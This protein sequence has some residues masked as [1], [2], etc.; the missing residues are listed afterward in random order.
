MNLS[1]YNSKIQSSLYFISEMKDKDPESALVKCDKLQKE[2]EEAH[3]DALIGFSHFTKAEIHY[4][5]NE[6]VDFYVEMAACLEPFERIEEWGYL[7]MANNMLGIMSLNRG[8]APFAMDY[9][10]KAMQYCKEHSLPDLMWIIRM[11]IGAVYFSIEE[12]D[13]ALN[14]YKNAYLSISEENDEYNYEEDRV[15][16]IISIANTY[17]ASENAE[18]A[19]STFEKISLS[20]RDDYSL[21][22]KLIIDCFA[23][24]LY[25]AQKDIEKAKEFIFA[26]HEEISNGITLMDV[27]EDIYEYLKMLLESSYYDEFLFVMR[28]V[29]DIV[30]KTGLKNLEKKCLV[31]CLK[32]YRKINDEDKYLEYA[33]K[34]FELD[35][36]LSNENRLMVTNMIRL[37]G[38]LYDLAKVNKEVEKEN[39]LL[40]EKAETDALT[41]LD[42]RF[43]LEKVRHEI[44]DRARKNNTP[45]AVEILDMDY[46]KQFNDNYGHQ[47]GDKA[48]CF[49]S[50]NIK[51]LAENR[52]I[53]TARYGGDEFIIIYENYSLEEVFS[54]AK[55]LKKNII[56]ANYKHEYSL[57]PEKIITVS[58]GI[59]FGFPDEE[60]KFKH[61]LHSADGLLYKAKLTKR[62]CIALSSSAD[63]GEKVLEA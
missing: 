10:Y 41:K 20:D 9:Y 35:D 29:L 58:Q 32:Y 4:Q 45:V 44:F 60:A 18:K 30:S 47:A 16:A 12:Y 17:L 46:F 31:L 5:L 24:R 36:R 21:I 3:D 55:E 25:Q 52:N 59:F 43:G 8:N 7:A 34:Y 54:F 63:A 19:N 42:N 11:N 62:N 28:M 27:F 2:G 14:Y 13:D 38:S 61:Y 37:K 48:I 22:T 26:V 33:A 39:R 6:P 1:N 23:A 57:L 56:S 15:Y 40:N 51:K 50:D 49:V 53:H